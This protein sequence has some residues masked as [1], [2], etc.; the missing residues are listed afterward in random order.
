MRVKGAKLALEEKQRQAA[1]RPTFA[2]FATG[3]SQQELKKST[4]IAGGGQELP[5]ELQNSI[6]IFKI[7]LDGGFYLR[8]ERASPLSTIQFRTCSSR[9][10]VNRGF[11]LVLAS[12]ELK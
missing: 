4:S 6:S 5:S 7:P 2:C 12:P 9:Y 11:T 10:C 8:G 3:R 1:D